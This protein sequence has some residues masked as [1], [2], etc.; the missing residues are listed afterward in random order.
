MLPSFRDVIRYEKVIP[1]SSPSSSYEDVRG[2]L[3]AWVKRGFVL[4]GLTTALPRRSLAADL[5]F[6]P[7][8]SDSVSILRGPAGREVCLIGTAH[9]SEES[10]E[11]VRRTIKSLKPDVV[12]IELDKKRMA[13][14]V[15]Q[16]GRE[17]SLEE[18]GFME[19]RMAIAAPIPPAEGGV[20]TP[21]VSSSDSATPS[22]PVPATPQAKD[23]RGG[24]VNGF[25]AVVG[26][27][28]QSIAGNALK[29]GLGQFYDSVEKL[30]FTAGKE[31]IV[32]CEEAKKL[33]A[34]VLLGD[35]DVDITLGNLASALS[36]YAND[37]DKFL[38]LVE[39]LDDV[40]RELGIELPQNTDDST[41]KA[42]L[43]SMVEKLKTRQALDKIMGILKAEAP[44]I[45][46]AM[47]GDRDAYMAASI[48]NQADSQVL[49]AVCGMA[50]L[51]G[52]ERNLSARGFRLTERKC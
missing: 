44:S 1:S 38:T 14:V 45:Y 3:S 17:V 46:Q 6:P 33:K 2:E 15:D 24:P 10:A 51:Q 20:T 49:V 36:L 28:V 47:I 52:I 4:A 25:L 11:V 12:M 41:S 23:P 48:A 50:H 18:R 29:K 21:V 39:K 13:R 9:I 5:A 22:I 7:D 31:F 19:P 34:P 8:C 43:A 37:A 26:R 42:A 35:Q 40:E 32:A 30:G 27:A 16:Q